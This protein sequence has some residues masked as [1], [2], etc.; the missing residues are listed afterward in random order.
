MGHQRQRCLTSGLELRSNLRCWA[1]LPGRTAWPPGSPARVGRTGHLRS[2]I[3]TGSGT[4]TMMSTH[5]CTRATQE[6]R[7]VVTNQLLRDIPGPGGEPDIVRLRA[8]A[9]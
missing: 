1:R 5:Q 6:T 2:V 3:L 7:T 4:T 8:R 9:D